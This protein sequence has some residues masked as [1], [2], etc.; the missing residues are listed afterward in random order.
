MSVASAGSM[1]HFIMAV[2]LLFC[3]FTFS[4]QQRIRWTVARL[5]PRRHADGSRDR[6]R[7]EGRR[8]DR[9]GRRHPRERLRP[10]GRPDPGSSGPD[11][12]DRCRAAAGRRSRRPRHSRTTTPRASRSA[13]SASERTTP[14]CTG[15][16]LRRTRR[17]HDVPRADVGVDQSARKLLLAVRS[18]ALRRHAARQASVQPRTPR[19]QAA[20][21]VSR[22][23]VIVRCRRSAPFASP[24]RPPSQACPSCSVPHRHQHLRRHL[25]PGAVAAPRRWA[26]RHRHLR[27]DPP[28]KGRRYRSTSRS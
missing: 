1:M 12:R 11:D 28:R 7:A 14:T 3:L 26:H 9:L 22:H 19:G 8:Q 21:A 13:S 25:Q 5:S 23:R 16:A 6:R 2:V 18:V 4:G 17:G 27:E 24:P 10:C 20:A 15:R